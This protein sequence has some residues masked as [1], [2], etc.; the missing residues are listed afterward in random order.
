MKRTFLI[1]SLVALFMP[2]ALHAAEGDAT[3]PF[4]AINTNPGS[5]ALGGVSLFDNSASVMFTDRRGHV[6]A[7]GAMWKPTDSYFAGGDLAFK[8]KDI[9]GIRAVV[10]DNIETPYDIYDEFGQVSGQFKPN[11]LKASLGVSAKFAK[12][13]SVGV[14][15]VYARRTLFTDQSYQTFG[16]NAAF[17]VDWKG[18]DIALGAKN[19]CVKVMDAEGNAFSLP[20]S[21][22]FDLGYDFLSRKENQSLVIA[23]ELEYFLAGKLAYGGGLKYACKVFNIAAGY[24]VGGVV[25]D[26]ASAG[27]GFNFSGVELKATALL[28]VKNI[29]MPSLLFGLGYSF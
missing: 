1:S 23:A 18:L 6:M 9:V 7:N 22:F 11:A 4:V 25:H 13:F 16:A 27:I 20:S 2:A 3:M 17:M 12:Y 28:D 8:V 29:G 5:V 26:Y 24:H 15:A 10:A 21:A 14:D 19:L